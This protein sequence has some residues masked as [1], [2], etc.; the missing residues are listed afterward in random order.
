MGILGNIAMSIGD[1]MSSKTPSERK[2]EIINAT[3]DVEYYANQMEKALIKL[4]LTGDMSNIIEM[5][6]AYEKTANRIAL[7][8][9]ALEKAQGI[10]AELEKVMENEL[11]NAA[12][13]FGIAWRK[14][15]TNEPL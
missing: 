15:H 8:L 11:G 7:N 5:Q 3:A 1:K 12:E 13:R 2:K 10:D 14:V 9:A 6:K 4:R